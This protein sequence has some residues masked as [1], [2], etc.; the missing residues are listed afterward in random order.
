MKYVPRWKEYRKGKLVQK[1][2][3]LLISLLIAASGCVAIAWLQ[4]FGLP[5]PLPTTQEAHK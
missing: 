1:G 5:L 4:H 3:A 2:E